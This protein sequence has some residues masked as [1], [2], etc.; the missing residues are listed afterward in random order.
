MKQ[1]LF[2]LIL[3]MSVS[4]FAAKY[5]IQVVKSRIAGKS[6]TIRAYHIYTQLVKD[7]SVIGS[8]GFDAGDNVSRAQ[9]MDIRGKL[10]STVRI[11]TDHLNYSPEEVKTV[12][13]SFS[14]METMEKWNYIRRGYLAYKDTGYNL[15]NNNC[16]IITERVLTQVVGLE[17]PLKMTNAQAHTGKVKTLVDNC[18]I[19]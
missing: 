14:T 17:Y 9:T 19:M 2:L 1:S 18:L 4:T 16:G 12:Y 15:F 11:N 13:E 5:E 3:T 6:Y 7:G 8:I 10:P